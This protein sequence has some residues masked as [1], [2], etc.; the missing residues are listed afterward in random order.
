MKRFN[1]NSYNEN[2]NQVVITRNEKPVEILR[3][4]LAG[5]KPILFIKK[6]SYGDY[7]YQATVDGRIY[8][9]DTSSEDLFFADEEEIADLEKK[10]E[11]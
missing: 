5:E 1:L 7:A 11:K 9:S 8:F 10:E 6:E 2:P 4:D 3:T